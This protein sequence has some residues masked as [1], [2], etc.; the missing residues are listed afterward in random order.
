MKG[1][2]RLYIGLSLTPTWLRGKSSHEEEGGKPIDMIEFYVGLAKMAERAKLDFVFRP[3]TLFLRVQQG[4]APQFGSIDPTI[5]MTAIARETERIGLVT[6]IS[7]TFNPPYV[8]A[9]QLQSLHWVSGGRAGWNIVTSLDGAENFS[10]APM[11]SAEEKYAIAREFTDVVSKLW[12]SYPYEALAGA[13]SPDSAG[14]GVQIAPID[15]EGPYFHVKGPLNT[16]AHYSGSV[17]LFQAGA[18]DTGRNFAASIANAIFASIP[19]ME[20]GIE[21]CQDLRRRAVQNGRE[22][23]AVR[24]LP[25]MYFFLGHTREEAHRMHEETHAAISV[26]RRYA[27]V[28]MILGIDLRQLPLD[29]KLT[30]DSLPDA[31][32]PVRSRT[33][34]D[35]LRRYIADNKPTVEQLL[36]RP[37]VVGSSHWVVI[38][39][40]DDAIDDIVTWF[41]AGAMDGFIAL[42]GGSELSLHLFFDEL[43]PK[44]VERGLYRSEYSG[45]TL[46]EHMD[47]A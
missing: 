3:D 43:M 16:A 44:L 18:S 2:R 4:R 15:H 12:E 27:S 46:R 39:T 7:T 8:V 33:H 21:L 35:L 23:E 38:G 5:M 30:R 9:R 14:S 28:E 42:P 40:V 13:S 37:E 47:M 22:P 19:D 1:R 26:E 45:T 32:Q 36:S 10:N 24:V 25:G 17:P 31:A 6:T 34:A 11:P 29:Y 41:E 20:A